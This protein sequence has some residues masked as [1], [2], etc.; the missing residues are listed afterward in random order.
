MPTPS[1]HLFSILSHPDFLSMKGLANEVPIFVHTYEPNEEDAVRQMVDNL[2]SRM[3]SGGIPLV[4]VD[5]FDVVV[6]DDQ[7]EVPTLISGDD[8]DLILNVGEK[9]IFEATGTAI[10]GQ[11]ANLAT[12]TALDILENQISDED[13]SHYFGVASGIDIEKSTNGQDAD[14]EMGP[15]IAAGNVVTWMYTVT[16]MGNVD[17]SK[18]SFVTSMPSWK[19]A[20]YGIRPIGSGFMTVGNSTKNPRQIQTLNQ[21]DESAPSGA[22]KTLD[23]IPR[24]A[25]SHFSCRPKTFWCEG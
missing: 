3:R 4:V 8:G 15:I 21:I 17:P 24:K 16:N 14:V 11:Y 18:R 9:W 19:K 6:I 25:D 22:T 20:C 12:V 1:E 10:E 7:G 23:R 13:P 2:A 5:L